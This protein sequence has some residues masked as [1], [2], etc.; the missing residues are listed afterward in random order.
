MR[1]Y[2][3]LGAINLFLSVAL[4]AFGAHVLDGKISAKMLEVYRTGVQYHM[5]HALG[6]LAVGLLAD[7]LAATKLLNTAGNLLFL[8]IILFSGSLYVLALTSV[9]ILGAIT[10]LGGVCF[11]VGWL[12]IV[13]AAM[14]Q[15]KESK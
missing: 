10:P 7:R 4:G 1:K 5:I 13:R 8:G 6:L 2:T 9:T 11:L 14:K 15:P 3:I 12:L